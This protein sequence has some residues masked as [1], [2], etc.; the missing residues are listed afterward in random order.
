MTQASSSQGERETPAQPAQLAQP[1]LQALPPVFEKSQT[2]FQ[3]EPTS[4]VLQYAP[5]QPPPGIAQQLPQPNEQ[6]RPWSRRWHLAKLA[7]GTGS[8]ITSVILI[9][10]SLTLIAKYGEYEAYDYYDLPI[11]VAFGFATGGLAMLWV[12]IEFLALVA[13][14]NQHGIHP[15]ASLSLHLIICLVTATAIGLTA[16]SL[17]WYLEE[18]LDDVPDDNGWKGYHASDGVANLRN[19]NA[20][21]AMTQL[22]EVIIAFMAI[23]EVI[24]LVLFLRACVE[25][26]QYNKWKLEHAT[27]TIYVPVPMA[28]GYYT[29]GPGPERMVFRP[30]PAQHPQQLQPTTQ[31]GPLA[32]A[33]AHLYGYYAPVQNPAQPA[34]HARTGNPPAEAR[35]AVAGSGR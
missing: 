31:G 25:T 33:Q 10:I 19:Y 22:V 9:A 32:P 23:L 1:Q 3:H 8:L 35:N 29:Q 30:V 7:L 12:I 27:R 20:L 28:Y 15:G 24:H 21:R 17:S 6:L 2:S 14:R 13:S 16:T 18:G 5:P 34:P 26:H 4:Q 11:P